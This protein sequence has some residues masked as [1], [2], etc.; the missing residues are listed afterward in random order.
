MPEKQGKGFWTQGA[1]PTNVTQRRCVHDE[2]GRVDPAKAAEPSKPRGSN[3]SK[4]PRLSDEHQSKK[5]KV[6]DDYAVFLPNSDIDAMIDPALMDPMLG[7]QYADSSMMISDVHALSTPPHTLTTQN[8]FATPGPFP[9]SVDPNIDPALMDPA[10]LESSNDVGMTDDTFKLL[11]SALPKIS[12]AVAGTPDIDKSFSPITAEEASADTTSK[13][14][15]EEQQ[16]LQTEDFHVS[17]VIQEPQVNGASHT[18]A[19][20]MEEDTDMPSLPPQQ[21]AMTPVER[22]G[23]DDRANV[24]LSTVVEPVSDADTIAVS[25]SIPKIEIETLKPLVKLEPQMAH[26]QDYQR[27][28]TVVSH[29]SSPEEDASERLARELQAQEHGLRRRPSVRIS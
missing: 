26:A 3:S 11:P 23:L 25:K 20:Q 28:D 16:Q 18:Q 27:A 4:R 1:D 2:H 19:D 21:K 22:Q 29:G 17:N 12:T 13:R 7:I 24:P 14:A 5:V 15:S 8:S 10:L 9:S 6:E